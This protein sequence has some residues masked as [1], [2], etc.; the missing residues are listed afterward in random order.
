MRASELIASLTAGVFESWDTPVDDGVIE[1]AY[2]D[3]LGRARERTGVDESVITGVGAVGRIRTVLI[4][5]EF[6]FLGGS[7]GAASGRRIVTAIRRATIERLPILAA[8][9]SGGTRMQEGTPAFL[10][11]VS[12]S[13]AVAAH[14]AA[15]L[16]Y[17]VYLR[18]PTTGGVFA[19]WGSMGQVTWAQPGALIG[20]LGPRV[21]QGLHGEPFPDDVQVSENLLRHRLIDDVVTLDELGDRLR[22]LLSQLVD[23]SEIVEPQHHSDYPTPVADAWAAVRATRAP[24]RP[25]LSELLASIP[26]ESIVGPGPVRLALANFGGVSALVVGQDRGVD[27][28]LLPADLALARRGIGLAAE[29]NLALVTVIDTSG[30]ALSVAAEEGGQ[31]G[32]IAACMAA[33]LATSSPTVAVLMGQGAGGG[34][35]ALFP[36]DWVIAADDAWLSPLPPEG[37]SLIMYRDTAH[38]SK[39]VGPQRIWS[40]DLHRLGVVDELTGSGGALVSDVVAAVSRRLTARPSPDPAKRVRL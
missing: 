12:I 33:L 34:A 28:E 17:L 18:H 23:S 29:W 21:Y 5:S 24:G 8:P 40:H 10:Q 6:G 19:S 11:M 37:A 32:Q 27:A 4:V 36:A 39:M 2:A 25:G 9:A 38:A 31:A 7:I 35:L 22:R 15:G 3:S 26:G 20:F 1:V 16:P 30:A 13:A 14:R